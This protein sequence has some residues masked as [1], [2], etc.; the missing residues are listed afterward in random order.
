MGGNLLSTVE[1]SSNTPWRFVDA[2]YQSSY[3]AS[4]IVPKMSW[5]PPGLFV[6]STLLPALG[7]TTVAAR[8]Y[9]RKQKGTPLRAD[10]WLAFVAMVEDSHR[11]QSLRH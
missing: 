8:F 9:V 5:T 11:I 2:S 7:T 10:D 4:D 6:V 1:P 3:F